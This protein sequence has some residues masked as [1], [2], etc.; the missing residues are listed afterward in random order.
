MARSLVEKALGEASEIE[1]DELPADRQRVVKAMKMKPHS[2]FDG[3]H[4]YVIMFDYR[5]ERLPAKLLK[6]LVNDKNFRWLEADGTQLNI[7]I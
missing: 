6:P 7:G 5:S 3:T 2:I 4:G 1:F